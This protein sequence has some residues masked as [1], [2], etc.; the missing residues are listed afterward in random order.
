MQKIYCYVNAISIIVIMIVIEINPIKKI[1]LLQPNF[2][3]FV[4]N[5]S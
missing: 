4:V 3:K 5:K 1:R 2:D